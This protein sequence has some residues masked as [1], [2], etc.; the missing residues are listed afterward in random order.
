MPYFRGVPEYTVVGAFAKDGDGTVYCHRHASEVD[1][2]HDPI[3][4]TEGDGFICD[5]CGQDVTEEYKDD[6]DEDD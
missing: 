3:F 2:E 6:R 5:T 4:L 1:L